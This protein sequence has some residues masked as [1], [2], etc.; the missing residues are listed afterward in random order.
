MLCF[1][2]SRTAAK[3]F[4]QHARHV[5]RSI[6]IHALRHASWRRDI[7]GQPIGQGLGTEIV[8]VKHIHQAQ[9]LEPLGADELFLARPDTRHDQGPLGKRQN[10]ADGVVASHGHHPVGQ[11]QKDVG[12]GDKLDHPQLRA[13]SRQPI[14]ALPRRPA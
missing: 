7:A 3:H 11:A 9:V 4:F 10:L 5:L 8:W 1:A 12:I 13:V 2:S 14:K 6:D